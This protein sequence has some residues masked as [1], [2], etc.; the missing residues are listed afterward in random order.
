MNKNEDQKNAPKEPER[1]LAEIT[2]AM[3]TLQMLN[4]WTCLL[5]F[6]WRQKAETSGPDD[7]KTRRTWTPLRSP[8]NF[9]MRQKGS[10]TDLLASR[11]A[12]FSFA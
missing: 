3:K 12:Q 4:C 7:N 8:E 11:G 2:T 1:L 10:G 6:K 9:A 5:L